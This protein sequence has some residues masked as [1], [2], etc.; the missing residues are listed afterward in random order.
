VYRQL[1]NPALYHTAYG[2][3]SRNDGAMT[4]GT[5]A[6]TVDGMSEEKIQGI[7]ALLREEK[8]RWSPVRR[9]YIP[10]ASDPTKTRPLGLPTWT[11]KL[12]QEVIRMLLEAYY[13]PQFDPHSHGFRP[14]RGCGSAL[15]EVYYGW[16]GT[17]WFIEGDI[18]GCFDNID[19]AVLLATIRRASTTIASCGC[20]MDYSRQDIWRI[21]ATTRR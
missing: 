10:K 14:G 9:V 17:T 15:A 2:K 13:E 16:R 1:Y 8:Y 11:D 12:L 21:G 6:E 4:P 7:I 20:W 18:K 5:T 19:H 3:I